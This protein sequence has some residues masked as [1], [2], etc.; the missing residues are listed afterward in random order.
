VPCILGSCNRQRAD[1][2][3]KEKIE[4]ETGGHRGGEEPA[5]HISNLS[6]S[7]CSPNNL[8]WSLLLQFHA[9]GLQSKTHH[10]VKCAKDS[11][12]LCG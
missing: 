5:A 4:E 12:G 6:K 11:E 1:P 8:L 3:A 2:V 10:S 7:Q 9:I